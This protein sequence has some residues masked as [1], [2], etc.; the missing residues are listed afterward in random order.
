[1]L[2]ILV[3]ELSVPDPAIPPVLPNGKPNPQFVEYRDLLASLVMVCP[4][5][6]RLQGFYTFYNHEFDRLT[7]ALSTRRNLKEHVWIVSENEAVTERSHFQISPGLLDEHQVYQFMHYHYA[8]SQLE[9]LM[10]CSPG[11]TGVLEHELFIRVF[12]LL[13]SLKHLCVSCFDGDDFSD[14]T[15]LALPAL[16][17]LRL[18]ECPGVS[19]YGLARWAATPNAQRVESLSLIHQNLGGLLTISK[20]LASLPQLLKFTIVQ[21]DV[22]PS[23][24]RDLMI[25]QPII[26]SPTLKHLHWD[27]AP[28]GHYTSTKYY[29]ELAPTGQNIHTANSQ[30]AASIL[31]AGFP[32][33]VTLRAPQD[34][35]PPGVLQEV[36]R[37]TPN[38]SILLPADRYGL[39]PKARGHNSAMPDFLP[40]TNSLHSARIRAQ[41]YIE[42]AS[43]SDKDFCKVIVTDHSNY[44]P[45]LHESTS[46]RYS[47]STGPTDPEDLFS[48][49]EDPLLDTSAD[50]PLSPTTPSSKEVSAAILSMLDASKIETK[51]KSITRPAPPGPLKVHEYTLPPFLGRVSVSFSSTASSDSNPPRFNLLP[52]VPGFDTEGGVIGWGDLLRLKEKDDRAVNGPAWIR[53]GCTGKWN[54]SC[55]KGPEWSRHTERERRGGTTIG[56]SHFF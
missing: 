17:S 27:V 31:H 9:T 4:N 29:A 20:L 28:S 51:T 6:E 15:L 30:L 22:S 5:L 32:N 56:T 23:L 46:T 18:E 35:D 52:D 26:A 14:H 47:I 25:F 40:T 43:K 55:A 39:P 2:G 37:P 34:L 10:F 13:P 16:V 19:E 41:S 1:M 24:P 38:A 54:Q 3:K 11:G 12:R 42:T 49:N 36:C 44:E 21:A 48:D 8:W 33:L 7:H 53:D 50:R 45:S